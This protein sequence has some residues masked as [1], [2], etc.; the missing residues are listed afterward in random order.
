MVSGG[1]G[2][3]QGP[4]APLARPRL[5]LLQ[6]HLRAAEPAGLLSMRCHSNRG[7]DSP[8]PKH[9]EVLSVIALPSHVQVLAELTQGLAVVR[10]QAVP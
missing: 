7:R 3:R 2:D 6:T 4:G 9:G 8:L 1:L 5:A 10:E